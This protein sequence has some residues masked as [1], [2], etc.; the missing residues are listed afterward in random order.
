VHWADQMSL[1]IE[2]VKETNV[3]L[4]GFVNQLKGEIVLFQKVI[5]ILSS[6]L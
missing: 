4:Y 1:N 3:Q 2:V 5:K 6:S